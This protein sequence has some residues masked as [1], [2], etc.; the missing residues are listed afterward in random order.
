MGH[1]LGATGCM[2]LGTTLDELERQNKSTALQCVGGGMKK[3]LLLNV[4]KRLCP[5]DRNEHNHLMLTLK[6]MCKLHT[7]GKNNK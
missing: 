4:F 5:L 7:T 1:P 3:Q 6:L 2:I